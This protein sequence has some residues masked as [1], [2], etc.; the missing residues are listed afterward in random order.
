[1][2]RALHDRNDIFEI[3]H[4]AKERQFTIDQKRKR[5]HLQMLEVLSWEH[6]AIA[7][8]EGLS[9]RHTPNAIQLRLD[10]ARKGDLVF[11]AFIIFRQHRLAEFHRVLFHTRLASP[12]R[13][14]AASDTFVS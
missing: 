7:R 10:V 6:L 4:I 14:S 5:F 9:V 11:I 1:M 2:A 12:L 8:P 3:R 13:L